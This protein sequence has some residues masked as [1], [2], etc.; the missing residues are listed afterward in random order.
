MKVISNAYGTGTV[1]ALRCEK[2]VKAIL[3]DIKGVEPEVSEEYG[4]E[5]YETYNDANGWLMVTIHPKKNG[6]QDYFIMRRDNKRH[7][8]TSLDVILHDDGR[9]WASTYTWEV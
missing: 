8:A 4:F 7:R 3:S 1:G 5:A 2:I 9:H 6:M